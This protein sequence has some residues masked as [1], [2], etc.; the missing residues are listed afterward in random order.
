MRRGTFFSVHHKGGRALSKDSN[1]HNSGH[2]FAWPPSLP[3]R[4]PQKG[5]NGIWA[6]ME[7]HRRGTLFAAWG[8]TF[9]LTCYVVVVATT[10]QAGRSL[11]SQEPVSA[12]GF[13]THAHGRAGP[14]SPGTGGGQTGVGHG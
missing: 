3:P 10:L 13:G 1:A 4:K 11:G 14:P 6:A 5:V 2:G 8:T 9:V 7:R 12:S